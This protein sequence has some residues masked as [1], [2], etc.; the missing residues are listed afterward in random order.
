MLPEWRHFYFLKIFKISS[1]GQNVA[2]PATFWQAL[3]N[4]KKYF[5]AILATFWPAL[6]NFEI[7]E[8][9]FY[10]H[11]GNILASARKF[12]KIWNWERGVD[13][14]GCST[15]FIIPFCL[16]YLSRYFGILNS[17]SNFLK[18]CDTLI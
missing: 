16:E 13:Y 8:K 5:V 3:E 17:T 14:K 9:T 11:S 15:V 4:L 2:I 10:C 12:W 6:E 18:F 7:F 1:A